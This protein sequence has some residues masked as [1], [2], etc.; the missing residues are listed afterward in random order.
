MVPTT[1]AE[2]E[3]RLRAEGFDEVLERR[4]PPDTV[5]PTHSHAFAVKALVVQGEMWLAQGGCTRH[6]RAGEAFELGRDL[7]H[8]ERYGATGTTV[9]VARRH[10]P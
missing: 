4:W 3:M 2:F 10:A 1:F 5:L 6:L 7:P 8:D 9:W